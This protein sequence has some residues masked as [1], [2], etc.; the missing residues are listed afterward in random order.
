MW[1]PQG[2]SPQHGQ[3]AGAEKGSAV[4]EQCLCAV[5]HAV[6]RRGKGERSEKKNI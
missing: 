4:V 3:G 1:W 6:K 2:A 5:C